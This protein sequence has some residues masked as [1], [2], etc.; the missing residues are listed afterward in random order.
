MKPDHYSESTE[1]VA[2]VWS[3]VLASP[4]IDPD[5]TFLEQGGDSLLA[6]VVVR[7]LLDR[8]RIRVSVAEVL[9]GLSVRGIASR[10]AEDKAAFSETTTAQERDVLD[11]ERW[12]LERGR[13]SFVGFAMEVRGPISD[14]LLD[15][16]VNAVCEFHD[17]LSWTFARGD[18]GW[19]ALRSA[20]P[21]LTVKDV[22]SANDALAQLVMAD[23]EREDA[24]LSIWLIRGRDRTIV[25]IQ[26]DHALLD[27]ESVEVFLDDVA[28]VYTLGGAVPPH[29]PSTI[30]EIS[31][32]LHARPEPTISSALEYWADVY[33][34][35]GGYPEL[36]RSRAMRPESVAA[37]GRYQ[38][39]LDP[40]I[41][42]GLR[43]RNSERGTTMITSTLAALLV[44]A[45]SIDPRSEGN[46]IGLLMA[47]S[48]RSIAEQAGAIGNFAHEVVLDLGAEVSDPGEAL[49]QV[50]D[51]MRKMMANDVLHRSKLLARFSPSGAQRSPGT[52]WFTIEDAHGWNPPALGGARL[53]PPEPLAPPSGVYAGLWVNARFDDAPA[54]ECVVGSPGLEAN[55]PKAFLS[56]WV[57]AMKEI[58]L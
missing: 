48:G 41:V 55:W 17:G 11:A 49:E 50:V 58:A 52:A 31:V 29:S 42:D 6:V 39:P 2:E 13:R 45:S 3:K 21:R 34:R 14:T 30:A 28:R 12:Q 10:A 35:L 8:L 7:R 4:D 16:A 23:R 15:E 57:D 5:R 43:R 53:G 44:A 36:V 20:P 51:G 26:A 22:E 27:G 46:Q 37:N 40:R 32:R 1:Q 19:R 33:E 25:A 18:T 24:H 38:Q 56:A 54:V 9:G 47:T